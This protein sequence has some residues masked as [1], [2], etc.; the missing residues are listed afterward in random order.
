MVSVMGQSIQLIGLPASGK[1]TFFGAVV[2]DFRQAGVAVYARHNDRL[3]PRL[4]TSYAARYGLEVGA[5]PVYRMFR[6]L[7]RRLLARLF[8]PSGLET[9]AFREFAS[10]HSELVSLV[11]G[12]TA[13][14]ISDV[15]ERRY[16]LDL[17]FDHFAHFH[18]AQSVM[19]PAAVLVTDP[20][21]IQRG[22]A[23]LGYGQ[24]ETQEA[25]LH[26]YL[27]LTPRPD[28]VIFVQAPS[29][30]CLERMHQ[31]G[32]PKRLRGKTDEQVRQ[33]LDTCAAYLTMTAEW[34]G[35]HKVPLIEVNNDR[36][37]AEAAEQFRSKWAAY[38]SQ[39]GSS[40]KGPTT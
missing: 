25:L 24:R 16:V 15:K 35:R 29:A 28:A 7:P 3:D 8:P 1:S 12:L 40:P 13:S 33:S 26:D 22:I 6:L 19:D 23:L 27:R 38:R 9:E 31:R 17:Y 20:G 34:L 36:G 18:M 21:L 14:H 2:E 4:L 5:G 39:S 32:L 30:V 37:R 10:R 11:L